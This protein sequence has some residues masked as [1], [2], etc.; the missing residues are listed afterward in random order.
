MKAVLE[1]LRMMRAV[2]VAILECLV[3]I[4]KDLEKRDQRD[5]PLD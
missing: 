2:A 4:R 5:A 3:G 1:E